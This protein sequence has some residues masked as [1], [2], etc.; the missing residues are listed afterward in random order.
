MI[1]RFL[2]LQEKQV[3]VMSYPSLCVLKNLTDAT[4]MIVCRCLGENVKIYTSSRINPN[5]YSL[6]VADT[7]CKLITAN[8]WIF[9]RHAV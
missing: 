6:S 9:I 1:S 8:F 5:L 4:I 7:N 3:A 2:L